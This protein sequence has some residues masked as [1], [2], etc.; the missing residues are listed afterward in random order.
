VSG[1]PTMLMQDFM[2]PQIE[3]EAVC[4]IVNSDHA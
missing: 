1:G 4:F 2:P 3:I